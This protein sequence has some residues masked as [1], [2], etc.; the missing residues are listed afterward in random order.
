M[1]E[2]AVDRLQDRLGVPRTPC[3]T[4]D[5]PLPGGGPALPAKGDPITPSLAR[6][7]AHYGSNAALVLERATILPGGLTPLCPHTWHVQAEVLHAVREEM[8]GSVGDILERRL[9]MR[10]TCACH[11]ADAAETVARLAGP[12][13]GWDAPEQARQ[14]AVYR[15]LVSASAP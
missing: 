10:H 12:L 6:L 4:L 15:E 2:E 7:Y 13:L 9:G 5:V 14:A 8:A 3:P 1:A 11:G